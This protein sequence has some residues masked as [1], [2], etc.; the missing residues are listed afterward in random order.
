MRDSINTTRNVRLGT[1][2]PTSG[3]WSVTNFPH[4][5]NNDQ[6]CAQW[7]AIESND[8]LYWIIWCLNSASTVPQV[9]CQKSQVRNRPP[10]MRKVRIQPRGLSVPNIPYLDANRGENWLR[11]WSD[12]TVGNDRIGWL[13][14]LHF[15]LRFP[16]FMKKFRTCTLNTVFLLSFKFEAIGGAL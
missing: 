1:D 7:S 4:W 11:I 13:W 14:F 10:Q 6:S 16:C 3:R 12:A 9:G 5:V 2:N 15:S 8:H